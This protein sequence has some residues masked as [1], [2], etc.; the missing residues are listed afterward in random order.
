MK[1]ISVRLGQFSYDILIRSGILGSLSEHILDLCDQKCVGIITDTNVAP[2]YADILKKEIGRSAQEVHI[3]TVKAGEEAKSPENAVLLVRKMLKLGFTRESV[4]VALGGGVIGDLTGFV[5]SVFLRGVPY[6]AVPT[7]LL[8]QVDSSVG[9]KTAVNLPEG[10]NLM[11]TF[12]QPKRVL[13][14]PDCLQT[15]NVREFSCGMAE[16]MKY[17]VIRDRELFDRLEECED[18]YK[19]AE[20]VIAASLRIKADIVERDERDTGERMLLNFGH[21]VGHAIEKHAG[22]GR[23]SHGAAVGIGM[24]KIAK[25][26]E[27]NG[28]TEAGTADRIKALCRKFSLPEDYP[29]S[30]DLI[31]GISYDKKNFGDALEIAVTERIGHAILKKVDPKAFIADLKRIW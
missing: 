14:D 6:I 16:V 27:A 4:L 5:A 25:Y 9:G 23:L 17:G 15:L 7:T 1:K 22:Y 21:T 12:Y 19:I 20:D 30:D 31:A 13:I 8:A 18:F 24:C 2:L 26:G 3:L 11:G 10:K 29:F 28:D